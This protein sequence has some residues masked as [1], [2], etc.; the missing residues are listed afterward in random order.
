MINTATI[1]GNRA[2]DFLNLYL[3]DGFAVVAISD[4]QMLKV[5]SRQLNDGQWHQISV[6]MPHD[7]S[8]LSEL[9]VKID[10]KQMD[11]SLSQG[12][13]HLYFN[14]SMRFTVGGRG[15]SGKALKKL[16]LKNFSGLIDDILLWSL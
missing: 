13:T 6:S 2:R 1:W 10:G 5:K 14:Q 15:Y 11:T 4:K 9:I 16:P 7:D 8:K 3:Y 12:D